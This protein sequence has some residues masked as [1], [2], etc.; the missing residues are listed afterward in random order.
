MRASTLL[1]V[2]LLGLAACTP[3]RSEVPALVPAQTTISREQ[4]VGALTAARP[5]IERRDYDQAR[6]RVTA[7]LGDAERWEWLDV[8]ADGEFLLG[9]IADRERKPR[10][11]ADA[12]ARAYDASRKLGDLERGV[13]TLNALTNSLLDAG[14]WDKA[15]AA[16]AEASRLAAR[17]GDVS[18]EA[19]AQNNLAEADRLAGRLAEARQGY[20]RAL[21]LAREAGDRAAEASILLNLGVT[22]RRAGRLGEARARFAEAQ[23]LAR[24]LADKRADAYAQWNLDQIEAE[25]RASGGS[26]TEG[27]NR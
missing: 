7:V 8:V 19:T 25:T 24:A 2:S 11:A 13:H 18:A 20:E 3:P 22:E 10:D 6:A 5:L 27:G 15:R 9:E 12:Y 1:A 21:Q 14:A 23:R 16:A 4:A 26:P 17:R